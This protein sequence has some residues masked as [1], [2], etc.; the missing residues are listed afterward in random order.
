MGRCGF[1]KGRFYKVPRI[2]EGHALSQESAYKRPASFRTHLFLSN[3][4]FNKLFNL[5]YY[6]TNK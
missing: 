6:D 4:Q 5:I 2:K 1:Y 3:Q